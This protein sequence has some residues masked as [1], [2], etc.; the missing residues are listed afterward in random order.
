[1]LQLALIGEPAEPAVP[2]GRRRLHAIVREAVAS[3]L[4]LLGLDRHAI[5]ETAQLVVDAL[6]KR[7]L[8]GDQRTLLMRFYGEEP[9]CWICGFQIAKD[10][11]A[12]S[13]AAFSVDHVVPRSH[14]GSQLGI[15]NLRPAHRLC[16][17]VRTAA[18]LRPRM[19]ARYEAFL[20][21]TRGG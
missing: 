21:K 8:F 14:G 10:A 9:A 7:R 6:S 17:A 1:M 4:G 12:D 5:D 15:T 2:N 20:A 16:N 19:R 13:D 18:Q 3:Q 11:P